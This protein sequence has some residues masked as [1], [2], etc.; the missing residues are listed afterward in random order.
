MSGMA[1]AFKT[2]AS[3]SPETDKSDYHLDHKAPALPLGS[4]FTV[5]SSRDGR[6]CS[7]NERLGYGML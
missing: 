7:A 6:A 4:P 5:P 1:S 3:K 2:V